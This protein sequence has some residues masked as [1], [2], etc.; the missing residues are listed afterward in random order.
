[1]A[2]E[3]AIDESGPTSATRRRTI[4]VKEPSIEEKWPSIEENW[5]VIEENWQV[6]EEEEQSIEEDWQVI[7]E[8]EQSIEDDCHLV[9][10]NEHL[11]WARCSASSIEC[12][13]GRERFHFAS[14]EEN[15]VSKK[16]KAS[17]RKS[18]FC[19]QEVQAV[20]IDS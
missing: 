16:E 10:E 13:L 1:V 9:V 8:K 7:E 6:I 12:T 15:L 4:R 5:Q 20:S 2:K 18:K 14:I 3:A 17:T 11:A 19:P